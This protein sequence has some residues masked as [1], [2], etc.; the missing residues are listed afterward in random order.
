[1]EETLGNNKKFR[2][3]TALFIY[4]GSLET[5]GSSTRP[6]I[7]GKLGKKDVITLLST[8]VR[9]VL[10]GSDNFVKN[11][12]DLEQSPHLKT[13]FEPKPELLE[14][15]KENR[16]APVSKSAENQGSTASKINYLEI[17]KQKIITDS[18]LGADWQE[19]Y[20]FL[21]QGL[22]LGEVKKA[23]TDIEAAMKEIKSRTEITLEIRNQAVET[24]EAQQKLLRLC[25]DKEIDRGIQISLLKESSLLFSKT[26]LQNDL[27][28]LVK[29]FSS[30][31]NSVKGQPKYSICDSD[32]PCDILLMGDEIN[33]SCQH[34]D[35]DPSFNAG[36]LGPLLDGKYRII[37]VKDE[38]GKMVARCLLKILW[39]E[40]GQTPVLFQERLYIN[41]PNNRTYHSELLDEMCRQKAQAM[42]LPLLKDASDR[43]N[44]Y[45]NPISSL[46][47]RSPVEYVDA[48][49][50]ITGNTYAIRDSKILWAP[51]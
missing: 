39:D 4:L 25:E 36:L 48:L 35:G 46:G 10:E 17:F 27:N 7:I 47:G 19:K 24:L 34:L 45:S 1:Y 2:D 13:I 21:A 29:S 33:G 12:Y 30:E 51:A 8:Y 41:Q 16:S 44:L 9:D 40:K 32:D 6:N 23:I 38:T 26:E 37:A 28:G 43:L 31:R 20:P 14:L 18:H 22:V 42:G 15:W 49:Y 50:G 5:I 11:R 3:P